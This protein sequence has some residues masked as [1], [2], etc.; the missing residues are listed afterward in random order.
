MPNEP[1]KFRTK[2]WVQINGDLHG[3]YDSKIQTKY[4]S[5]MLIS[6]LCDYR[7]ACILVKETTPAA[8]TAAAQAAANNPNKNVIFK[9][10]A[11]FTDSKSETNNTQIDNA[12]DIKVVNN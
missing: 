6:C 2:N 7:Y 10:C 3:T 8:N 12:K 11:P 4:K 9:N 5:I 1:S